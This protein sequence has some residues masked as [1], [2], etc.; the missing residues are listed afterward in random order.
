[1]SYDYIILASLTLTMISYSWVPC[2]IIAVL[3]ILWTYFFPNSINQR[4]RW[5]WCTKVALLLFAF[6]PYLTFFV[7]GGGKSEQVWLDKVIEHIEVKRD[8]CEDPEMKA[9][10]DYIARWYNY[11]GFC[12]VMVVQLPE[13]IL[14]LNVPHCPGITLDECHLRGTIKFAASTLVHEAMHDYP[15]YYCHFHIDD[16]HILETL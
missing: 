12:G 9:I 14:G 10:L 2:V 6:I 7:P 1:M 16:N 15:P 5:W 8:E 4:I 13:G 11:I 3:A